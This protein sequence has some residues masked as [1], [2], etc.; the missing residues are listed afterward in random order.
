MTQYI[1]ITPARDEEKL[2]PGLIDSMVS[3]TCPPSRWII[4]DDGSTDSTAEIIDAAARRNPWIDPQHLQHGRKRAPGGESV[5]MKFL[6]SEVLEKYQYILR[7][8]AD[9]SFPPDTVARLLEEFRRDPKLGIG[10]PILLEPSSTGW[11]EMGEPRFHAPGPL[12]LYST[13]CFKAIGG[14][15]PGLG[16]DTVDDMC[17]LMLGY[18]TCH[19]PHLRGFHHRPQGAASGAWR[20]RVAQGYAAYYA[21]YSPLFMLARAAVHSLMYP[22]IGGGVLM[23]AGYCRG[24]LQRWPRAGSAELT[25]F[26][27][28][29]QL[30]RLFMME[31]LWR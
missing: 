19:F 4:I 17:A 12:K 29:Q 23:F 21:G 28:R 2:L 25:R 20:N 14:L 27:R 16:W 18:R 10:G 7:A 5:I 30:R 26:I 31:T 1:A 15:K 3:Q 6:T 11:H 8:D 13:D 22:P 9:V 24:Y